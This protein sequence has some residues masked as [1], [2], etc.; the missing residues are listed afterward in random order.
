MSEKIYKFGVVGA[1]MI[2]QFHA[3]ALAAMQGAELVA[4][5]DR[6]RDRA[7]AYA[8]QHGCAAYDNMD[9]FLAHEDLDVVTICTPSGAHF[10]PALAA[11]QAAKHAPS[12]SSSADTNGLQS[13]W[14]TDLPDI[15]AWLFP[16][17]R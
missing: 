15:Q 14:S 17:E 5:F 6:H 10:E 2:S 1:G 16:H 7:E 13:L 4:V 9:A 3:L 8:Q 12:S 11:A